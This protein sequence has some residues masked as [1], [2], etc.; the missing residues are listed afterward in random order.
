VTARRPT[1]SGDDEVTTVDVRGVDVARMLPK[2]DDGPGPARRIASARNAAMVASIVGRAL[3]E[4]MPTDELDVAETAP[5]EVPRPEPRRVARRIGVFAAAIVATTVGAAAAAAWIVTR[6]PAMP[7]VASAPEP[8]EEPAA[9][10]V[11]TIAPRVESIAP[12][13]EPEPAAAPPPPPPDLDLPA[14]SAPPRARHAAA[15]P[16]EDA[17]PADA[18]VEDVLAVA[19]QRR[20][21]KRWR[22]AAELYE[23]VRTS[24]PRT[25]A[26]IVATVAAAALHLDHLDDAAGARRRFDA[27][28]RLAPSGPLAEEASWGLVE[29]ARALD[30]LAGERAALRA[31]LA[32]HADSPNAPAAR[33]RLAELEREAP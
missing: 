14:E 9:P 15:R 23:R 11:R 28:L 26:A 32:G 30:D 19:N 24:Y 29:C 31:F 4:S 6:P 8:R 21:A 33:Q 1:D 27:A 3:A 20:K 22:D 18:P 16:A 12:Q 25:D 2:L 7:R 10:R 13:A 17:P 5:R